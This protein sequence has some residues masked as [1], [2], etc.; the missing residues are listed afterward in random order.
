MYPSLQNF[1]VLR[2]HDNYDSLK[3]LKFYAND[4]SINEV[5]YKMW[6]NLI[7]EGFK[8]VDISDF[9]SEQE[10]NSNRLP[11]SSLKYEFM[12]KFIPA[13][14]EATNLKENVQ[15]VKKETKT[16]YPKTEKSVVIVKA[17]NKNVSEQKQIIQT[18]VQDN[19]QNVVNTDKQENLIISEQQNEQIEIKKKNTFWSK[20]KTKF[21]K[22]DK[23]KKRFKNL[24]SRNHK[25]KKSTQNE[26]EF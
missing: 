13:F 4:S 25:K 3:Q 12:Q 6:Q 17:K 15:P 20:L 26:T 1:V 19:S 16:V 24:F 21:Q 9:A 14:L 18:D 7:N 2:I 5:E 22:K 11:D 8:I 10:I 23:K